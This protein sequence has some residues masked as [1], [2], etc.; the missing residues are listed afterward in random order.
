[1]NYNELLSSNTRADDYVNATKLC[2]VHDKRLDNWLANAETK[3]YL[4]TLESQGIKYK[5]SRPGVGTYLHPLATIKLAEWLSPEFEV[6]V[7]S[8]FKRY[9][10]GDVTLATEIV[11]RS[12]DK[13]AVDKH[14]EDA[15]IQS[16]YLDTF[17]GLGAE[18]KQHGCNGSHYGTVHGHINNLVGVP[19]GKR[20][21]MTRKQRLQ[22]M[23]AQGAGEIALM[24][25]EQRGW[26]AVSLVKRASSHALSSAK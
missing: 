24:D 11:N 20:P 19:K 14:I 17:H 12:T 2:K 25:S 3:Q 7:K 4:L 22:M 10:T 21:E 13:A 26:N 6:F 8:T 5:Y 18:L 1:M 15:K 16:Q 9:L 23:M